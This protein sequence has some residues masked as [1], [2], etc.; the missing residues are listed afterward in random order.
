MLPPDYLE[1]AH[2]GYALTGHVSQGVTVERTYLLASP[3][4]GGAEWAYVAGSRHRLDLRVYAITDEPD[5]TAEAL[6]ATWERRQ[7]KH[8]ALERIE[9]A[10]EASPGPQPPGR[11]GPAIPELAAPEAPLDLDALAPSATP[12]WPSCARAGRPTRHGSRASLAPRPSN[13][14]LSA[15]TQG[16]SRPRPTRR[17]PTSAASACL[18]APGWPRRRTGGT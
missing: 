2:Y 10:Q 1:H 7:A 6:A 12:W 18:G 5:Q 14:A 4:R 3:E 15:S 8:L 17:G 13:C 11:P 16:T 9:A